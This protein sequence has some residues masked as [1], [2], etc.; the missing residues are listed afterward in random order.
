MALP[1]ISGPDFGTPESIVKEIRR[2][3]LWGMGLNLLLVGAKAFGGIVFHS[4][5]LL[6]D[7]V[8]SLSDLV[9][10]FAIILGVK[11]WSAPPDRCHPYGHGRIETLISA[12]IGLALAAVAAGLIW[13]A[14]NSLRIGLERQ[15]G[16]DALLIA[17]ISIVSKE[18]LFRWT[19]R[20][21]RAVKSRATEA[22]AWHHRSDAISSIPAAIAIAVAY[23]FPDLH[24]VD[25]LGAILVS[26]FILHAAWR[27]TLPTLRELCDSGVSQEAEERI[28]EISIGVEGVMA[29]HAIRPRN[30][31]SSVLADLHVKVDPEMSVRDGHALTH[32]VRRALEESELNITDVVIHLEPYT[33]SEHDSK[34]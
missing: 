11:F 28:Y 10:D 31:G 15:P 7:A 3:T 21:A 23:F 9:T 13:D 18:W 29:V 30:A 19:R 6:A 4:Q 26:F 2:V 20:V 22:N 32:R 8:H 17:L 5:A 14:V 12:F 1:R 33:P 16:I 34:R 27:I 24:W 25:Q